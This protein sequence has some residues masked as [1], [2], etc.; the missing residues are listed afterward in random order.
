MIKWQ[1]NETLENNQSRINVVINWA[2]K[3]P[4]QEIL[5]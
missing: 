1:N 5:T 3:E 4:E 2:V